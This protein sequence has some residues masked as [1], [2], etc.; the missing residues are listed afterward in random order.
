MTRFSVPISCPYRTGFTFK[1][2]TPEEAYSPKNRHENLAI[3]RKMAC[4]STQ[5]FLHAAFALATP[6]FQCTDAG[7]RRFSMNLWKFRQVFA[8]IFWRFGVGDVPTESARGLAQ[9]KTWR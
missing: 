3:D 9:S 4:D 8:P 7:P 6:E 5:P 2:H 1:A